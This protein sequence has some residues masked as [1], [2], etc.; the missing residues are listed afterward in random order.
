MIHHLAIADLVINAALNTVPM[1]GAV[2]KRLL[3]DKSPSAKQVG[4]DL[5]AERAALWASLEREGILEPLKA[6]KD[7][8]GR[9]IIDDGRHRY[10]W[11]LA[12]GKATVPVVEVTPAQGQALI[13]ATV[14]GRRHWTKGQRAYLGVLLHPE[15]TEAQPGRPK[16]TDS[17]GNYLNA[18]DLSERLGVSVDTI[19]QAVELYRAFHSPGA[20]PGSPEAIE[21]ADLK[22]RYEMSIWAGAGLGAVIAGIA[23]GQST[24]GKTRPESG[25]HSLDKPLATLGRLSGLFAKWDE[26]ERGKALRLMTSRLKESTSP[27]FRLALSEALAAAAD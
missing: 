2:A 27:E 18:T 7:A 10:E 12:T 25:F 3:G 8:Q 19:H 5:D 6:H 21:A 24:G 16:N 9:W 26:V 20:K 15:V 13:E 11:A 22:D 14:I 1:I 4:K 17:V 23:G